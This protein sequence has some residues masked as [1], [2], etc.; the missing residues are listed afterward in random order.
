MEVC[1]DQDTDLDPRLL[2]SVVVAFVQGAAVQSVR[3]PAS[4]A[5]EGF[6][7]G[8]GLLAPHPVLPHPCSP[9]PCSPTPC[10]LT[11]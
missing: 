2:A 11:P 3:D 6:L 8:L 10:S 4:Y 9:T 1:A 5:P 7:A